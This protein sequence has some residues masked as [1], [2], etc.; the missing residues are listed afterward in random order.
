MALSAAATWQLRN[1]GNI[2]WG[3][4]QVNTGV[5][6]WKHALLGAGKDQQAIIAS[7]AASAH[8]LGVA[9]E[10]YATSLATALVTAVYFWGC[11]VRLPASATTTVQWIG[12]MVVAQSDNVIAGIAGLTQGEPIGVLKELDGTSYVW[13]DIGAYPLGTTA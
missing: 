12:K 13:V 6:V 2:K 4:C 11:E 5:K 9:K 10:T 8:F 3:K 7:T 1:T